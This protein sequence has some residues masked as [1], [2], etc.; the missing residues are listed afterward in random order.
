MGIVNLLS[1]RKYG[2]TRIFQR[3]AFRTY[4][5]LLHFVWN[6]NRYNSETK[7]MKKVN[8]HSKANVWENKK[9]SKA[10]GFLHI[11]C[12]TLI[13]S[14]PKIWEK[15]IPIVREMGKI[16]KNTNISKLRVPK[17]WEKWILIVQEKCEK[18]Q[19]FQIYGFIKYFGWSRNSYIS[20]NMGKVNLLSTRK[21]W[22][23]TE[24][25]HIDFPNILFAS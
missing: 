13:H 16:W 1:T 15:W 8:S 22:E 7:N 4:S 5:E 10:L 6:G 14:I 19:A 9:H 23:N 21:V 2:K 11:S 24:I 17:T 3:Y 12:E 20:Q 25:F 18:T